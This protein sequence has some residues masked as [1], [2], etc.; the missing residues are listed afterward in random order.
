VESTI[1]R[2]LA[3]VLEEWVGKDVPPPAS[4]YPSNANG[5]AAPPADQSAVGFP[6]LSSLGITYP[7]G[8]YNP[9]VVTKYTT[10]GIPFLDLSENYTV[11]VSKTDSDG[12]ELAGV[13]VPEVVAPLATY[14]SWNIRTTGHAP[15]DGGYYLGSTFVFASTEAQR[16]ANGD[17]RPSL[18]ARYSSKAAYVN[19][20]QAAAEALVQQRLLL[21]EDVAV[22]VEEAQ[23]QTVLP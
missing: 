11:L 1:D 13:R 19:K 10:G 6:N 21:Q 17:P 23:S 18:A 22:Y 2:A 9:L 4:L 3:P 7:A 8:L 14:T 20:V 5:L 12:N 16:I 15:G